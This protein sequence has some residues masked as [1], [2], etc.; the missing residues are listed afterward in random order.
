MTFLGEPIA[1]SATQSSGGRSGPTVTLNLDAPA[2]NATT[3]KSIKGTAEIS[4]VSRTQL[5][6]DDLKAMNGKALLDPKLKN[7][8]ILST[9]KTNRIDDTELTL[10]VPAE[11][12]KL[13]YWGLR[14]GKA[15]CELISEGSIPNKD[16][17]V[18]LT[19]TYTGNRLKTAFLG[20]VILE[21]TDPKRLEFHFKDVTLP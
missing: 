9:V 6:F 15:E 8:E 16:G 13:A 21:P 14:E 20:M 2:R 18:L 12:A 11:H 5:K 1:A 17:S 10:K 7:F 4:R 3:I 19:K